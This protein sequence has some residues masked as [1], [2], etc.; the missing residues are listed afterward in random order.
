M[1]TITVKELDP[2]FKYDV[3]AQPGGE[4]IKRC[5]A[6]GVCTGGCLVSEIDEHFDPRKIIRML[7]LGM[8]ERVLSS[9]SIW[10][11]LLCYNCS[12]HCPQ[13]VNFS[14]VIGAL[15][16]MA[17]KEGYV[18]PSLL[19]RLVFQNLLPSPK[20]LDFLLSRPFSLYQRSGLQ[21]LVRRSGVLS[22]FSER[23][24][25]LEYLLPPLSFRPARNQLTEVMPAKGE[26]KQRVGFFLGCA[27]NLVFTTTSLATVSILTKNSCE[28]VIP[29]DLKC[30]GMPCMGYGEIEQ[31]RKLAKH[32]IDVFSSTAVEVI[33]TD[34]AT[35]GS[36]LKWYHTLLK[37]DPEYAEPALAFSKKIQDISEFLTQSISLRQDLGEIR[38]KVTYHDPCHLVREQKVA[39]QPRQLL[40]LIPGLE[41][42]EMK[43]ADV[44]CGG[45]GSYNLTHYE[46]SMKILDRKMTNIAAT[47]ADLIATGCPGC[48]MQLRLGVKR[49]GLNARVVHPIQLLAQ[50]YRN[51]EE[52]TIR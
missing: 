28:V 40:N 9:P 33:V 34:C 46:T 8:R 37:E 38:G 52:L 5:F 27:Q 26:R 20:S 1:R 19:R 24:R 3:A 41:L 32:N 12:F 48:Q 31:A 42:I 2:K 6:C 50:A 22:I 43:E 49:K 10:L 44:C 14:D 29:N 30:C 47:D 45:A 13:D 15:R 23:L 35:C 39:H 21:S 36:F 18:H 16:Y 51:A 25:S 4:N 17:I 7:L 11:C